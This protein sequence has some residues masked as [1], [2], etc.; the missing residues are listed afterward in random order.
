MSNISPKIDVVAKV[1]LFNAAGAALILK[2]GEN[3]VSPAKSFRPDLPGGTVDPGESGRQA[4]A[5]ELVEETGVTL[6]ETDFELVYARTEYRKSRN[7][8]I[9]KELYLARCDNAPDI[10][11]SRE[12]EGYY[13]ASIDDLKAGIDLTSFYVEALG[14]L[15]D[16]KI[17]LG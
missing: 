5:R 3:A 17:L 6:A 4:V 2:N 1:L 14:Y 8:S 16:H 15:I 7:E 10:R 12:H 13:W 9:T 11:L